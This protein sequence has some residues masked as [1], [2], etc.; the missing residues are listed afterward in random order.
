MDSDE[1]GAS[2]LDESCGEVAADE[3]DIETSLG[4]NTQ[5][6]ERA[7]PF[8]ETLEMEVSMRPQESS[9]NAWVIFGL[10]QDIEMISRY[11][12]TRARGADRMI[13][14]ISA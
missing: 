12:A 10:L 11:A 4:D 14:A 2:C 9:E 1:E 13:S 5:Y 6:H 8:S 3:Q 7:T